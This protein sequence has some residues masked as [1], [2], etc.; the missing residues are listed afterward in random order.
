MSENECPFCEI[1]AGRAPA[2]V[3]TESMACLEI[4]PL[5]PVVDGHTIVIPRRHVQDA[6]DD[7]WTTGAAA[8]DAAWFASLRAKGDPRYESVN[9]IT[10]VGVPAT[11]SVFHLHVHV[12]PRATNDG[13]ALPW[14]SGKS[15]RKD[16]PC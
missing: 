6:Y 4:V 15:R 13:L 16:R 8:R 14:Y 7:V 10:S 1:V 2:E 5:N 11:Q 12:V 3:V 9:L